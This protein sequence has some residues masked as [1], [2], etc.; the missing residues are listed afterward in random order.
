MNLLLY[1][2]PGSGKGT[3]AEMLHKRF[4]IPHI[5][6]GDILRNE[7]AAGTPLG[8]KAKPIMAAGGYVPDDVMIG[9][10]RNRLAQPDCVNGFIMDGF[11]RTIPQA[12]ALDE[13]LTELSKAF[14]RVLYLKVETSELVKRLA[15]RMTCP[16]DQ[17]TYPP[18]TRTCPADGTKLVQRDDDKPDAVKH[19]I[20]IYLEKTL[21]LLD[22]YRARHLVS[23]IEGV[24]TI[25][26]IHGSVLSALEKARVTN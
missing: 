2:P 16:V 14:D 13:L 8:L 23:E 11:P 9:I 5:A 18:G 24:G 12:Q 21:P 19:R 1:G 6:T 26:E 15:G 4:D 25:D 22:Y 3:Q 10:I 7:V 17:K 20:E